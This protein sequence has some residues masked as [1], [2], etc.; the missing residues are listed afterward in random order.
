MV[1]ELPG[2]EA[3]RSAR[4]DASQERSSPGRWGRQ[5]RLRRLCWQR[6]P[7]PLHLRARALPSQSGPPREPDRCRNG[8][9]TRSTY[10][11]HRT[12]CSRK[13]GKFSSMSPSLGFVLNRSSA[14]RRF[15]SGLSS[16]ESGRP[17]LSA[18]RSIGE[19]AHIASDEPGPRPGKAL[20]YRPGSTATQARPRQH[21]TMN[22]YH[23]APPVEKGNVQ[24]MPHRQR[25]HIAT[26]RE[27]HD[28]RI[29]PASRQ[30][31]QPQKRA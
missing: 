12:G 28:R 18:S 11:C 16:C 17:R 13:L 4:A 25:V 9:G 3:P 5:N 15:R 6:T 14:A 7:L 19:Q 24:R 1:S 30:S 8:T 31:A 22:R 23:P 10:P 2:A 29:R 21:E 20:H 27:H 26:A